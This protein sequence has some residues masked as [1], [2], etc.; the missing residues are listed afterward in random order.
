ME[1]TGQLLKKESGRIHSLDF[2]R[3]ISI[4]AIILVHSTAEFLDNYMHVASGAEFVFANIFNAIASFGMPAFIMVS[5]ALML[6]ENRQLTIKDV[7]TKKIKSIAIIFLVWTV[8]YAIVYAILYPLWQGQSINLFNVFNALINGHFHMWF[9]FLIVGLYAITPL[10]KCFISKE[11]SHLALYFV[12]LALPV[13]F[14][15]PI[16]A[17]LVAKLPSLSL[18]VDFINA[19]NLEFVAGYT[20]YYI[21]GWYIVHVGFSKTQKTWLYVLGA[22]SLIATIVIMQFMPTKAGSMYNIKNVLIFIYTIAIFTLIHNTYKNKGKFG[23]AVQKLSA[24]SFGIYIVHPLFTF[25]F[26]YFIPYWGKLVPVYMMIKWV[27]V[28]VLS[29]AVSYVISKIPFVKKA[30]RA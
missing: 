29:L 1:T 17:L 6:D 10:L 13:V 11:K 27:T 25:A 20:S 3:V 26:D 22:A 21:M 15:K 19:F 14:L 5:G 12:L 28:T 24:L 16:L 18:V 4:V 2:L 7:W 8:F 23:M 30:I 9:L